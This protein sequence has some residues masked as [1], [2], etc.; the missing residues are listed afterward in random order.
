VTADAAITGVLLTGTI[1]AGK[2]TAAE[3]VSDRLHEEAIQHALLD[4][5]WLG[6]VYPPPDRG[7]PYN[8]TLAITNLRVIWP[9]F[10]HTG[11]RHV[12]LAATVITRPQLD[13][14][15]AAMPGCSLTVVR[16]VARPET[17]A[18]RLAG[19]D[20]GRLL[21]DFLRGTDAIAEEIE[22]AALESFHVRTD[23]QVP[24]EVAEEILGRLGW[25][26]E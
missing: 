13:R 25:L 3:A 8:E 14:L 10:V 23:D 19:R 4:L 16:V 18:G 11:I 15:D 22:R 26:D 6:Q 20:S 9:N 7:D 24:E 2:T 5:D 1:G 21:E 12:I 17:V